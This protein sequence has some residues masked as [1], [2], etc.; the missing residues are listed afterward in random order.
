MRIKSQRNDFYRKLD[1]IGDSFNLSLAV[2]RIKQI[3]GMLKTRNFKPRRS[4]KKTSSIRPGTN[5]KKLNIETVFVVSFFGFG[6]VWKTVS[7]MEKRDVRSALVNYGRKIGKQ[8][9]RVKK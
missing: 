8:L 1:L 5:R 3:R 4:I 2:P 7:I 9:V 6:W